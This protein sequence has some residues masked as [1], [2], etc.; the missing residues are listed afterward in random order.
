[1]ASIAKKNQAGRD[2]W[3][4]RFYVDGRRRELYVP[5]SGKKA[6]R[7]AITISRHCE[8]LAGAKANNVPPALD[9]VAWA[10]GATGK[11]RENLVAWGLA[12]PINPRLMTDAGR[13]LGAFCDAY[14]KSRTDAKPNTI[15]NFKQA[16]RLLCEHFGEQCRIDSITPS[17]AEKWRR[18]MT[19]ER[20]LAPA[21]ANKH[22]KRA[23]TFFAD[24]VG[25]RL[26]AVSP[27]AEL[28]CGSEVNPDRQRFID[29][30][31]AE[32]IL[33][34]CPDADWRSI[35]A[36]ARFGGLRC[37][38]EVLGL[39]WTDIDW[40]AG[41]IRIES[42]KTGLRFCALFPELR[43]LL[44]EASELAPDGAVYVVGRYRSIQNI[45]TQFVR[46][47]ERAGLVPWPKPFVNLR[48]SRRTE[49]QERFPSHV[50]NTWLGQSTAIAE[51]H[52]L[53]TTDAH[54]QAAIEVGAPTGA[55]ITIKTASISKNHETK[56]PR[57]NRGSDGLSS[58]VITYSIPPRG[59]EPLLPD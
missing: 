19:A 38:T 12:E 39:R 22:A 48:A 37:P 18:W 15:A 31:M 25:D 27:F 2:G 47:I 42:P 43:E 14:I 17:A 46:I 8:E 44:W 6:E 13:F 33:E 49:L 10:A 51:K 54:W 3:R 45:R 34:S 52:Y 5:G 24:A 7:Q 41:R 1:M 56:K 57:K 29:R 36:L 40:D 55:P 9:A 26:L 53:Q 23:K 4:I 59:L 30:T 16:R 20:K 28:K 32:R 35:F 21:T 50:I 58:A 11:L